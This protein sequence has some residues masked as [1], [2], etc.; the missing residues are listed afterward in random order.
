MF[1]FIFLIFHFVWAILSGI[2]LGGD[3]SQCKDL[4][5][6]YF[7]WLVNIFCWLYMTFGLTFGCC[8]LCYASLSDIKIPGFVS[9]NNASTR[10]PPQQQTYNNNTYMQNQAQP[11]YYEHY[12]QNQGYGVNQNYA[13]NTQMNAYNYPPAP[14]QQPQKKGF[15]SQIGGF[16]SKKK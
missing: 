11:Q 12:Q 1:Y 10:R 3:T 9:G 13:A 8:A 14:Q 4:T 16:F 5:G 6:Y 15:L 7:A 2:W